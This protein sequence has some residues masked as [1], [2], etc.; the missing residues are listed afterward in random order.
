M[1]VGEFFTR[2]IRLI[3][4]GP[5]D[6]RNENGMG[7]DTHTGVTDIPVTDTIVACDPEKSAEMSST[8]LQHALKLEKQGGATR[9]IR[10]EIP[11]HVSLDC[12]MMEY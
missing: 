9:F 12:T 8:G 2:G 10:H 1:H 3:K 4:V 11:F 5:T 6:V 7:R